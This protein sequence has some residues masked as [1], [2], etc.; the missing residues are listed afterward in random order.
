MTP[1]DIND[2]YRT[3]YMWLRNATDTG[4]LPPPVPYSIVS[5]VLAA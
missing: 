5:G 2:A 3:Y 1:E 4:T